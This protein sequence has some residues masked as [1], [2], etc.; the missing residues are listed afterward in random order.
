MAYLK[1]SMGTPPVGREMAVPAP[2]R[3]YHDS[4]ISQ[5]DVRNAFESGWNI[6]EEEEVAGRQSL[7]SVDPAKGKR[8]QVAST[9]DAPSN[10]LR[11]KAWSQIRC[12]GR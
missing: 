3:L 10:L 8:S 11:R 1:P 7:L 4:T 12:R 6:G 5:L 9:L 2:R